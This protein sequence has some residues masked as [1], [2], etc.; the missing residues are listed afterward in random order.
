MPFVQVSSN[1]AKDSV[2]ADAAVHALS[3]ALSEALDRPEQVVMAKLEVGVPMIFQGST[4][5]RDDD[6]TGL[7][8][9]TTDSS[10]E[11]PCAMIQMRSI[12][13][14]DAE[15]NPVT[16]K[17]LTDTVHQALAVPIDRIFV[18]L[19]DIA[20]TNWGMNGNLVQL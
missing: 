2:D 1:V 15:R 10:W 5:V 9:V 12:G 11:Q 19:D 14:I 4:A 17:A 20:M 13:R 3:K 6:L 7:I 18:T 8:D 16:V